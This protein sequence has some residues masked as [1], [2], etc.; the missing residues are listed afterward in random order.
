MWVPCDVLCPASR[1]MAKQG[2][3]WDERSHRRCGGVSLAW[4]L[5]MF[6]REDSQDICSEM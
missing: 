6:L 5:L 4:L 1:G 2:C 3:V